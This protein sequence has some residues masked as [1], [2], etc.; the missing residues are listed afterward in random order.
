MTCVSV[1]D[2]TKRKTKIGKRIEANFADSAILVEE[3]LDSIPA[4]VFLHSSVDALIHGM[5]IFVAPTSNPFNEVFCKGA[6]EIIV[7]NYK[8]LAEEGI[9]K[10]FEYIGEFLRAS[11]F[12]GI[13]LSNVT[14]GAVHALA[15]HFGSVH[16]VPYGES[17]LRFL[18]AVFSKYAEISPSGKLEELA[19]IINEILGID[20]DIVSSF[21][22]L[23]ELIEKLIPKKRLREYGMIREDIPNYADKVIESQQRLLINN[24]VPLSKEDL[25]SIYERIY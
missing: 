25:I 19:N 12:A 8:K 18:T 9:D 11:A 14:C 4:K 1:V 2:I 7:T 6:I 22:T 10:R 17:N 13:A 24:F 5:E 20:T 21:L 16:N 15:M 23:E 3:L